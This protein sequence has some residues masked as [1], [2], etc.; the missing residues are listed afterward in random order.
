MQTVYRTVSFFLKGYMYIKVGKARKEREDEKG[1]REVCNKNV[2]IFISEL[3]I[4]SKFSNFLKS[5][6][7]FKIT[8]QFISECDIIKCQF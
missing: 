1:T 2:N 3:Y 5:F 8:F 7:L 4:L 6:L